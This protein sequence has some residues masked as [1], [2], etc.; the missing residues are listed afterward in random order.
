M[1]ARIIRMR[2]VMLAAIAVSCTALGGLALASAPALAASGYKFAFSFNGAETAFGS[3]GGTVGLAVDNSTGADTHKGDV[4]V[5]DQGNNA[6]D[7]FTSAG[8]FKTGVVVGG[9]GPNQLIVDNYPGANE[10]NV[11]V[12]DYSSGGVYSFGAG[13]TGEKEVTNAAGATGV[14]VDA[15]GDF[16]ISQVFAGTVLE[17]NSNWEPINV[18]GTVV[19]PGENVVVEGLSGPQTLAVD[20]AGDI[21][22]ATGAGTIE[23]AVSAGKYVEVK[24]LTEASS[25]GVTV[26][27]SGNVFVDISTE[28]VEYE[29]SGKV[30]TSFGSGIIGQGFGV[31]VN[32]SGVAYVSDIANE[33]VQVFEPGVATPEQ[34]LTVKK[35]GTGA[36]EAK[37][38]CEGET[39][40]KTVEPCEGVVKFPE[41]EKVKLTEKAEGTTFEGWGKAC[42][43]AGTAL[44]CTVTM[45]EPVEVTTTNLAQVFQ[46]FPVTVSVEG[47]GEVTSTPPGIACGLLCEAEFEETKPVELKATPESGWKFEEWVGG[48]CPGSKEATCKFPMPKAATNGGEAKFGVITTS[49]LTVFVSGKGEVSSTAGAPGSISCHSGEE[50]TA[51]FEGEVTLEEKEVA[52]ATF[53]GW[54]GCEHMSGTTCKV[55]VTAAKQVMAVFLGEGKE[56]KEGPVGKEGPIGKEGPKGAQGSAG[57]KGETGAAGAN[58]ANGEKGANGANGAN[59]AAGAQGPAGPAGAAGPAGPA[60]KVT[61][62]VQQK[63]K[64]VK[65]TC[66]VKVAKASA[67]R[68]HWNL[69]RH[70]HAVAHG[71][72]RGG[73][74]RLDASGLPAGKYTL[75]LISG[76][77]SHE[78][79]QREAFTLG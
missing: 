22:A 50:C 26:A 60:G 45:S 38:A 1:L 55:D 49:P 17:F 29:P 69:S 54:I 39:T 27:P 57:A 44:E 18:A 74:V 21:Y 33:V 25:F 72:S 64:K 43:S 46:K 40:K 35:E 73:N 56:G 48:P 65:V 78:T 52:G 51:E 28:V 75:T 53:V 34:P 4:Y 42:K 20:A 61:C 58:G 15:A 16:F 24:K 9:N 63:G 66:T 11:Y 76:Q 23:F 31:G 14:G 70:G 5:V 37:V 59:G 30:V 79:I 8:K 12:A 7:E 32:E 2:R 41:G 68:I 6:V 67:A 10:G 13:L 77:G 19:S 47:K 3:F 62:K 36:S 71:A